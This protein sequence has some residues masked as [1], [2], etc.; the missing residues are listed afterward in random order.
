MIGAH[1]PPG[2]YLGEACFWPGAGPLLFPRDSC[3]TLCCYLFHI[4]S[5]DITHGAWP[6]KFSVG[7]RL[8]SRKQAQVI[9]S[10]KLDRDRS[11]L[12]GPLDSGTNWSS[13]G[14][15]A[16]EADH[17]CI[18]RP[19]NIFSPANLGATGPGEAQLGGHTMLDESNTGLVQ[20]EASPSQIPL[21]WCR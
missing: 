7:K 19:T 18:P 3:A 15:G 9:H 8:W 21:S 16:V 2:H 12:G 14:F 11:K 13:A 20:S 6:R 10:S 4:A 1:P 17:Q 5:A